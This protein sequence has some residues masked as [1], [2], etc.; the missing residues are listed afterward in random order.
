[1]RILH[2]FWIIIQVQMARRKGATKKISKCISLSEE[3][4]KRLDEFCS[5]NYNAERSAVVEDALKKF[6][7]EKRIP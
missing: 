6:F 3:T 1:M 4:L 5:Q 7:Q 2:I